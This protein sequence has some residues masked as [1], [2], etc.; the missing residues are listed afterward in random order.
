MFLILD[1]LYLWHLDMAVWNPCGLSKPYGNTVLVQHLFRKRFVAWQHQVIAWT[2]VHQWGPVTFIQGLFHKRY[3]SHQSPNLTWKLL[4]PN[5]IGIS[6]EPMS[7]PRFNELWHWQEFDELY[8]YARDIFYWN[9][10]INDILCIWCFYNFP[11]SVIKQSAL[12]H[13]MFYSV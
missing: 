10:K 13:E 8:S 7:Q 1:G 12:S 6:K 11:M 4:I 5:F 3:I 9:G 2:N